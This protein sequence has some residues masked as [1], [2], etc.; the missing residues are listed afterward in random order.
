MGKRRG[1]GS[2][3]VGMYGRAALNLQQTGLAGLRCIIVY[4]KG[5]A[6]AHQGSCGDE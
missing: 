1:L 6:M 2:L 5:N 4:G 3:H